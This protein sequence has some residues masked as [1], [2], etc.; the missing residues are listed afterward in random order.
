LEVGKDG[1]FAIYNGHPLSAFS[2]CEMTF[3]EGEL[4]FSRADSPTAMSRAAQAI[5]AKPPQ[6][7]LASEKVRDRT[8]DLAVPAH[9]RYALTGATLYP[10]GG[11]VIANGVLLMENGKI[12]GIGKSL[13]IPTGSQVIDVAGMHVAPGF[14]DAGTQLGLIEIKKVTETQDFAEGG[15][16]QPDLRAGVGLNVDSELIPVARSGGITTIMIRPSGGMIAGQT[17][18]AQLSGWTAP[19]MVQN[20]EAG[21]QVIWTGDKKQQDELR[22]FLEEARLYDRLQSAAEKQNREGPITDPRLEA[23][24]PYINREKPVFVEAETRKSIA[25]ALLFAESEKLKIIITGGTDAWQLAEELKKRET[26]VIVG[27]VMRSPVSISDPFDAPYTNPGRLF[28]AGVKFCIR[29]DDA[30]NSRNTPF[31]AAMA[32][33]HGLP[34]DQ[35][36]R[37]VTLSAA[38]ILGIEKEVGSLTPQKTANLVILDGDPLEHTSHIKGVFIAGKPFTPDSRQIRFYNRYRERLLEK[39]TTPTQTNAGEEGKAVAE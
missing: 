23:L 38:E 15:I 21:L 35:G 5:S 1:D 2:R 33:A 22:E 10:V 8:L 24:R 16:F 14:I 20:Y 3:I 13:Q 32:V 9:G 27:P 31:E 18:I 29:S 19:E 28:E 4:Y 30:S 17:S 26:P 6:L 36:L 37:A 12:T 7:K 11:P 25:E 34:K 39:K